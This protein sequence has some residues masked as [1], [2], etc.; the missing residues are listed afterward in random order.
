MGRH[1][2]ISDLHLGASYI[3][4]PRAHEQRVV[5]FLD[6][7]K[8]DATSLFMLGDILDYWFEYRYVVPRGHVRFFGKLA[9]LADAG[10][11]LYWL[12]GNHDVWLRDYLRDEIGITIFYG[13]NTINVDGHEVFIS[14]GDDVGKQDMGYKFIRH[15]FYSPFNQWLYASI[16]PR[17]STWLATHWSAS[18]RTSRDANKEHQKIVEATGN[19]SQFAHQY[20]SSHPEVKHFVFGHLHLAKTEPLNDGNIIFLG[21]WIEQNTYAVMED[22]KIELNH[23]E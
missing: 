6:S 19:L 15:I 22:G 2:F 21:D 12:T 11:K 10:I 5:Q 20:A 3:Q 18:N 16:H 1:Y 4:D 7:I 8:H 14:H 13:H 17:W 23:W 9:E